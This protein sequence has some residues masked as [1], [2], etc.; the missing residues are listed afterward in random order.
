MKK[1]LSFLLVF[2][3]L[4]T[5]INTAS[6][7]DIPSSKE[8]VVYGILDL[9]G[10]VNNLYVVNIFKGGSITDFG[11]YTDIYNM[12]TSEEIN[13][14]G[15]KIT[16]NTDADKFYYQGTLENIELP[17]DIDINYYLDDKEI[18]GK[19][20]AGRSG[21]FKITMSIKQNT[22]INKTFFDN[23]ALQIAFSFDNKLC[24]NIKTDGATIAEAGSKKQLTY[25]VLPGNSMDIIVTAD[26]HD[27]E[28]EAI[29]ISGIKLSLGLNVDTDE[30]TEQISELT[31]AIKGLDDGADELL[32]GLNE[33]SVGMQKYID[34]MKAFN[35][36]LAELSKGADSLNEGAQSLNNG[37]SQ[38]ISQNDSIINGALAIQQATF[39]SINS[40]LSAMSLGLPT[41][42]PE[43]YG[44]ILTPIPD[45]VDA[46]EQLD[47][48][49]EFTQG[50]TSYMNGV[51]HLGDGAYDLAGGTAEFKS[52]SSV[53][54]ASA[55]E[56]YS[57]GVELNKAIKKLQEGFSTYKKGTKEL[58]NG[59]SGMNSDIDKMINE[60]LS[61]ISGN[62]D[63]VVSFVSDKNT[64]ISAVQFVVKTDSINLPETEKSDDE[65][66]VE[67]NFWQKLLELFG[68]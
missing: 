56:L 16:I 41:L 39:D 68:L 27:F 14:N 31:T 42:T 45:L 20:L 53:I 24:S 40:Q 59:T 60:M 37:L 46:K 36:G 66:P 47:S 11:S 57:S 17:W 49:V 19:D 54:A 9:D 26:V 58:R 51:A 61:S 6:A 18:T 28:M 3:F 64:N 7:E 63:E 30:F 21:N 12:T 32:N 67:L 34:G 44:A 29:S 25:T 5:L 62:D 50:L 2:G 22:E 13:R 52:S 35:E 10:N 43:N 8:E 33:L 1:I 15:D 38:L 65:E 48:I 55:N 23:Y 4:F